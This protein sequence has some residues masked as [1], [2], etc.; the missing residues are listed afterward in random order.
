MNLE[1]LIDG[2]HELS[3][4]EC[5]FARKPWSPTSEAIAAP[6]G[7]DFQVPSNLPIE[8]LEY[9]LEVPVV[10]EVLEVLGDKPASKEEQLKLLIF[11]ATN[12]SYP[13]WVYKR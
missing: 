8:G 7:D 13:D 4:D 1:Q 9:F 6:L 2:L 5:I 11:Y 10:K 3:E 12:D